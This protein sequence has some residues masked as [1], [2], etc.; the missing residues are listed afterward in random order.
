MARAAGVY[1]VRLA[2]TGMPKEELARM[3]KQLQDE[4]HRA[5][6]R[7]ESG[8]VTQTN[9]SIAGRDGRQFVSGGMLA[10]R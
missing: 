8:R 4:K 3:V 9:S 10:R 7:P 5:L 1:T 6:R 2:V